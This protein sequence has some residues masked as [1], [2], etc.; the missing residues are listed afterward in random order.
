[1]ATG[2]KEIPLPGAMVS[3]SHPRT[4]LNPDEY[5]AVIGVRIEGD[6]VYARGEHTCWFNIDMLTPA[7]DSSSRKEP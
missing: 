1:M 5:F 6:R 2:W 3:S 7:P 4:C